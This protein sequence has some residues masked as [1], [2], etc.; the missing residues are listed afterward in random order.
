MHTRTTLT[1]DSIHACMLIRFSRVQLFTTLW[2]IARQTPLSMEFSR[3]EYW[4][5]LPF[6]PLGYLANSGI[7]L[8][9][10]ASPPWQKDSLLASHLGSHQG[11]T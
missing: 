10:L 3:Q 1:Y 2:I 8:T 9:S 5:G 11:A 7:K 6:P 4:S